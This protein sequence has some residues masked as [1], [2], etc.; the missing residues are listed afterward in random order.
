MVCKTRISEGLNCS[1]VI[2][3]LHQGLKGK[4]RKAPYERT[5]RSFGFVSALRTWNEKPARV[6]KKLFH[7]L[8]L[9]KHL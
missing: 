8:N 5:L 2:P 7:Y 6:P 9:I 1:W 3:E 4:A